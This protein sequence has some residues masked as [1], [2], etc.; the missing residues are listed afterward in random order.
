MPLVRLYPKFPYCCA[1]Q[2]LYTKL[3]LLFPF[4]GPLSETDFK[5]VHKA[6]YRVRYK[7]H[8]IG[9]EFGLSIDDLSSIAS[10]PTLRNHDAR[11]SE[12]IALWLK[13]RDPTPTWKELIEA[14]QSETVGEEGLAADLKEKLTKK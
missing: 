12:M 10:E 9:I 6:L 14:L 4:T 5:G 3:K 2:H 1:E 11:L 7:W 13:R 8:A